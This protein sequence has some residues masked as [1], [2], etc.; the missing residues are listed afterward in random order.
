MAQVFCDAGLARQ[1][2]GQRKSVEF[3]FHEAPDMWLPVYSIQR[4]DDEI[5]QVL[6]RISVSSWAGEFLWIS[7]RAVDNFRGAQ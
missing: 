6:L 1:L 7:V 3:S 5:F 4:G 2:L